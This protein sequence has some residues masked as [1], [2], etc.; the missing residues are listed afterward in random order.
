MD[1]WLDAAAVAGILRLSED[2]VYRLVNARE[3]PA[4]RWP[5]RVSRGELDEYVE[6]SRV[7]RRKDAGAGGR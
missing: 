3:L 7:G 4:A 1:E 5:L 2:A 6:R